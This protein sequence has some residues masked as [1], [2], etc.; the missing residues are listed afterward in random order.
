MVGGTGVDVPRFDPVSLCVPGRV[1][2]CC[3]SCAGRPR[4]PRVAELPVSAG[5]AGN[6]TPLNYGVPLQYESSSVMV[7]SSA[8]PSDCPAFATDCLESEK[9]SFWD[10]TKVSG[11]VR[12]RHGTDFSRVNRPTRNRQRLRARLG[13]TYKHSDPIEAGIRF[14]TG[15]RKF[16]LDAGDRSGSPLSY[17]D[18]GDVFDKVEFNLDRLFITYRPTIVP[19]LFITGGKFK[20]PVRLNPIFSSPV[21]DLVWDEAAHPEGVAI[22]YTLRDVF[23]LD[24]IYV[25]VGESAVL[26]LGN[27]DDASLFFGQIW[28]ERRFGSSVKMTASCAYYDWNNLNPDGNTTISTE[29]NAGNSVT[30]VGIDTPQIGVDNLNNPVIDGS[31]LYVFDSGFQIINPMFTVTF[32]TEDDCSRL[33]PLQ[34]VWEAFHNLDSYASDRDSGASAGFQYGPAVGKKGR[35]ASSTIRTTMSSRK[36]SSRRSPKTTFN[37][38]P[39]LKDTGLASICSRSITWSFGCG[40]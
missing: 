31:P 25:T 26:E 2:T 12:V 7:S 24:E 20:H 34:L 13:L 28:A 33:Y 38:R 8:E 9:K 16:A 27:H 36:A 18:T 5:P 6:Y 22:G 15:D 30:Q 10:K 29:N 4:L 19:D 21:G 32:G 35:S 11:H 17:Q 37:E 14:T 3:G 40:C 1:A 23:G 39:I